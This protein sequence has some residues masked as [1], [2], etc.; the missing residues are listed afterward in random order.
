M[1]IY[2]CRNLVSVGLHV[3]MYV[4]MYVC[5][6]VRMYVCMCIYT[7]IYIHAHY[8]TTIPGS[9]VDDVIQDL[10]HQHKCAMFEVSGSEI[11]EGSVWRKEPQRF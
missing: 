1:Y 7:Y 11:F 2:I 10:N 5:R 6:Y 3:C 9:L 8:T 4:C